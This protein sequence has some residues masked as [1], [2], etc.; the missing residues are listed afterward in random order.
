ML[1]KETRQ[2]PSSVPRLRYFLA[3]KPNAVPPATFLFEA[4][5]LFE[6]TLLFE[7]FF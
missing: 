1:T 6:A 3:P 4:T 7:A 2:E 5:Y